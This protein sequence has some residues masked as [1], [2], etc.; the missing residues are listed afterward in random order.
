MM[1]KSSIELAESICLCDGNW[2][3]CAAHFLD[4]TETK[5][6]LYAQSDGNFF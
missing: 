2:L 5:E 4:S 6:P 3:V 1:Q